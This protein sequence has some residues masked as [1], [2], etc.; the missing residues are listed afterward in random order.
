MNVIKISINRKKNSFLF[1]ASEFYY[2]TIP[3]YE[4]APRGCYHGNHEKIPFIS[5]SSPDNC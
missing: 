1:Y 5:G 4:I 3:T 2:F